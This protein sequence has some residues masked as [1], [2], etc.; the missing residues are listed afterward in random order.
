M[1]NSEVKKG[2]QLTLGM[3]V[4]LVAGNMIGAGVF[5][6]PSELARIGNISFL[7]GVGI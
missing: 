2:S 3:L 1:K 4:A 7:S 6:L 5:L